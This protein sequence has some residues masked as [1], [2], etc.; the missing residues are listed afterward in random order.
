[1]RQ[2]LIDASAPNQPLHQNANNPQLV[3]MAN[4]VLR[5]MEDPPAHR[6]VGA[7]WLNNGRLL[8]EMDS[9]EA[10]TW[11]SRPHNKA[12]FLSQFVPDAAFK[13]RTYSLVVQ[14]VLLHFRPD[15]EGELRVLEELNKL[16]PNTFLHACWI[17]PPYCRA[18]E[19]TCGHVLA[20]MTRPEDANTVLTDGLIICQKRVYAEKCKKEPTCCL[21]CHGWG[22]LSYDCQQPFSTCGTCAGHH[23]TS[24]CTNRNRPRCVSCRMD[25]HPSW[26]HRCP[27][28]LNKCHDMDMRMTEN[29]MPYYPTADP[30]THALRPPK[31]TPPA[32]VPPQTQPCS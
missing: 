3:S 15:D 9:E 30:W 13:S 27:A 28:F 6:F 25:G 29:Q 8:L 32:P 11:I 7:W 20:V 24:D 21:K 16:P 1:M 18:V 2:V 12:A 31:P 26:D 4:D 17:K 19:Q 23:Q 5:G 22:H 14:F 10:A